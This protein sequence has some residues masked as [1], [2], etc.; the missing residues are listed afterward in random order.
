MEHG[1]HHEEGHANDPMGK[2]VAVQAAVL[3]VLLT[4]CTI[5]SHRTHTAAVIE[6]A[7]ANDTWNEYQAKKLKLHNRELG[8]DLIAILAAKGEAADE[9][10]GEYK[11]D[12]ERYDKDAEKLIEKARE[13]DKDVKHTEAKAVYFDLGEG[14]L[15]I[16]LIMSSLYFIGKK[17][18]FPIVGVLAG[19]AGVVLGILGHLH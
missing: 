6:K 4:V 2:R 15:E 8:R 3:A 14:L 18:L 1:G 7:D 12:I 9:K 17:A 13:K 16:A 11:K 5:M 10:L 19:I